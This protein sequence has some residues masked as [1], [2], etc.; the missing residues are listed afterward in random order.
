MV[1]SYMVA[2]EYNMVWAQMVEYKAEHEVLLS[3]HMVEYEYN[4]VYTYIL[5][6]QIQ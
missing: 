1:S 2:Y 4:M 6:T 3:S 5:W